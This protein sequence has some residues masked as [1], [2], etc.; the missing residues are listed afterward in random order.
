[1][2]NVKL[3]EELIKLAEEVSLDPTTFY[4]SDT[5]VWDEFKGTEPEWTDAQYK[6]YSR[7]VEI[8]GRLVK[9]GANVDDVLQRLKFSL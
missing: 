1:M 8:L 2:D 5:E 6:L 9:S 4:D 7:A 3:A